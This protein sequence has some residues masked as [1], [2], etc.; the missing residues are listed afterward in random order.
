MLKYLYIT[1]IISSFVFTS[2][3]NSTDINLDLPFKEFTVVNAELL[4]DTL[5]QG[6]TI[7]HTLPLGV[8]YDIRK[9]EIKNAVGYILE[10]RVKVVTIHYFSEGLYKPNREITI[11]PGSEYEL[12]VE[13]N[14]ESVYSKTLVPEIP[15]IIQTTNAGNNYLVAD[16]TAKPG[17]AYGAAWIISSGEGQPVREANDFHSIV[18]GNHFPSDLNVR[19]SNIP[20]PYNNPTY[21]NLFF[22]QVYSFDKAYKDYYISKTNSDPVNNTFTSGGGPVAWNVYG[23]N[24]IGLFIGMAKTNAVHP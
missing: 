11:N 2:C 1:I 17:E 16:I 14:G 15:D 12:F 21:S 13:I 6:V 18:M 8:E 4:A 23:K 9:A 24:V 20:S 10:N 5:F 22:I 3:E 7:T 19:T